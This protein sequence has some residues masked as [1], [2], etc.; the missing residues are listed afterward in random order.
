MSNYLLQKKKENAPAS[1]LKNMKQ[2]LDPPLH[3]C[4]TN[5]LPPPMCNSPASPPSNAIPI[6]KQCFQ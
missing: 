3:V 5:P 6:R 2:P 4:Y 1:Q